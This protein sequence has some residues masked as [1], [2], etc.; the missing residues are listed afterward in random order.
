MAM[1]ILARTRWRHR[2]ISRVFD[3]HYFLFAAKVE[4]SL[5]DIVPLRVSVLDT[6]LSDLAAFVV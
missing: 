4:C 2:H 1:F 5:V 6:P 3:R